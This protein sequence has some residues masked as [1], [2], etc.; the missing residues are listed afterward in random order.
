MSAVPV[1]HESYDEA[2][3]ITLGQNIPSQA[4]AIYV[5]GAGNIM[6]VVRGSGSVVPFMG[7]VAGT[8]IPFAP[9]SIESNG[10]NATNLVWLG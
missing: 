3:L 7:A 5:G 9:E 6:M 1:H 10:T 8:V 4:R 2:G